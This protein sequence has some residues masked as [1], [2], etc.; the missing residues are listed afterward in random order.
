MNCRFFAAAFFVLTSAVHAQQRWEKMDYGP[1]LSASFTSSPN[2]QF[3]NDDGHWSNTDVTP[4]GIA[5]KLDDKW[6]AGVIFDCDA[7]RISA[8]WIG[9]PLRLKGVPYGGEHGPVP[10]LSVAPL[11]QTPYGPGWADK[12]GSFKEPRADTIAPLPPPGRLP[13]DWAKYKGLYRYGDQVVL[14]YSVGKCAVLESPSLE[15]HA[16]AKAIARTFRL[17]STTVP[18]SLMIA[19]IKDATGQVAATSAILGDL[20]I[21]LV[22]APAGAKLVAT[23][24]GQ[25]HFNIPPQRAPTTFKVLLTGGGEA[26][27][28]NF[29]ALLKA[30]PK[31]ADLAMLT[32]GGPAKWTAPIETKGKLGTGDGPYVVDTITAPDENPY[33]AWMRFGGFDFFKDGTRAALCTWSGDVWI[34]SGINDKQHKSQAHIQRWL[35]SSVT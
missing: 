33:N 1:F 29:V 22:G 5:I 21:A 23:T 2:G 11:F 3:R 10:S 28:P 6:N 30:S 34:V 17:N 4:R 24:E 9:G 12:T 8:G 15:T 25:I 13:D 32:K 31:P 20:N 19:E 16:D 7:M 27:R 26:A 14:Y 35:I 18:L